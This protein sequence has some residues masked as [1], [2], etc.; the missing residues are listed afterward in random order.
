MP[1]KPPPQPISQLQPG[2]KI[3]PALD[4]IYTTPHKRQSLSPSP[5]TPRSTYRRSSTGLLGRKSTSSSVSSIRSIHHHHHTHSKASSTSS[6]GSVATS[7]VSL[8]TRSPHHS[9][10]VLP[11]TPTTSAFPSNIRVVR[12]T[13]ISSFNEGAWPQNFGSNGTGL[14]F[15]KRKKN[16]FKGPMLN[17]SSP[18]ASGNGGSSIRAGSHSRS[19]S[20][21][22]RRSGEITGI[23][24]EDEDEVEE[25]DAFSPIT[26]P[27]E[28]EE[29]IFAPGEIPK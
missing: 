17:T 7:K 4:R 27:G 20:V 24:E 19:T 25:V 18:S 15:A 23:E 29:T 21:A 28:I 12:Q 14:V 6:N 3:H 26:G 2:P 1:T 16:L 9:V 11:A 8:P 22:G 13:P 5:L 10:K